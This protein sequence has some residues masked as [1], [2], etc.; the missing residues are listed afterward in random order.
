M[1]VTRLK[2][3]AIPVGAIAFAIALT[4]SRAAGAQSSVSSSRGLSL[5]GTWMVEVTLRDCQSNAALASFPG[6]V[7]FA[8]G[9]TMVEVSSTRGL[10]PGQR[11]NGLGVWSHERRQ[12]YS[13]HFVALINFDTPPGPPGPPG[14]LAGW[15]TVTG[16]IELTDRDHYAG[17]GT[18]NLYNSNGQLYRTGCSSSVGQRVVSPAS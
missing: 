7:T 12:T 17:A 11:S 16:T 14:L 9:G 5:Q 1:T 8:R 18:V 4:A 10:P 6:L 3:L 15:Q 13:A 2:V